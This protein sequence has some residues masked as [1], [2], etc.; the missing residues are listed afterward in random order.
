MVMFCSFAIEHNSLE[1]SLSE[2]VLAMSYL[3]V[4]GRDSK[5]LV[6]VIQHQ[7][8][9]GESAGEDKLGQEVAGQ[10]YSKNELGCF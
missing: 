6:P 3:A 8:L 5:Q 1:E 9:T 4:T 10:K 7:L 2:H